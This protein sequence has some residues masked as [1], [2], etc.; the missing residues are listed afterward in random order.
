MD[1]NNKSFED[2]D[3]EPYVD[4]DDECG[5]WCVFRR[6]KAIATF[7]AEED[8]KEYLENM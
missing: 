5:M 3:N 2:V 1:F 4:Y 8:A 6:E 7:S